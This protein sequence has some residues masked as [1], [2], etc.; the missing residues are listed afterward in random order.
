MARAA[1]CVRAGELGYKLAARQFGVPKGTLE[2]Y[3]RAKD[4]PID[5]LVNVSL[6]RKPAEFLKIS[7]QPHRLFIVDETDITVVQ[8]KTE[9][10]LS[11]KVGTYV[12]PLIVWPRKNMKMELMDGAPAGAIWGCHPSGWIQADLFTMWFDHFINFT[13]PTA[14]DPV[15]LVLDGHYSHTRN[16]DLINKA[17]ENHIIIIC[18]PPHS[19]QRMQSL[20]FCFMKPL[21]TYCAAEIETWLRNHP[22]R[23]VTPF[24]F[25]AHKDEPLQEENGTTPPDTDDAVES[26]E[27][28]AGVS[29]SDIRP[30]PRIQPAASSS[31]R[32]S[33]S[34]VTSS[35][36]KAS[37]LE[38]QAKIRGKKKSGDGAV[39]GKGNGAA[40]RSL[41]GKKKKATRPDQEE[42]SEEESD[43]KY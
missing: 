24:D 10:V 22:D 8:H 34:V 42:T 43:P 11:L 21:K 39:N 16:I 17:R 6:G 7:G 9:K 18:L 15:L 4:K 38:S 35:P 36:Y 12:P 28:Q 41:I 1:K 27:C 32:G 2:R 33:A 29:P 14:E 5:D 30:L 3:V 31:R 25:P 37:L 23:V 19:S 26:T 40:R 13:K 20:N